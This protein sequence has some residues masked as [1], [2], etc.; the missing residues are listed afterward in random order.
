MVTPEEALAPYGLAKKR[1]GFEKDR[2][3][4][5]FTAFRYMP[6]GADKGY[7]VF[8][9]MAKRICR[10]HE[11][12]YFHVVGGFDENDLDV[13]SL[14]GHITFYGKQ[15][16]DWFDVFYQDKDLIVSPNVPDVLARYKLHAF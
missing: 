6:D 1:Y 11:N 8:V 7:D 3:D 10:N 15:H 4:V 13:S 12:V 14:K 2:L 16:A 5:V 9:D